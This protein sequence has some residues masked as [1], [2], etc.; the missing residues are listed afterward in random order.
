MKENE[1]VYDIYL[2][3]PISS[4]GDEGT[5]I[6]YLASA[7]HF[8]RAAGYS[9]FSPPEQETRG[10]VWEDYLKRD[11]QHLLKSRVIVMLPR[12]ELS[13]GARLEREIASKLGIKVVI[14]TELLKG[15]VE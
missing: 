10:H 3:G 13:R 4:W 15:I 7:A 6:S 8:F 2:S 14:L 5:N 1:V 11:I 12:W 9:V